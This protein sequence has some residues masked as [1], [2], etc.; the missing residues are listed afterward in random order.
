MDVI[1]VV[2][3]VV[4]AVGLSDVSFWLFLILSLLSAQLEYLNLCKTPFMCSS[5]SCSSCG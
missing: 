2:V 3:I 1:V 5:S 4:D